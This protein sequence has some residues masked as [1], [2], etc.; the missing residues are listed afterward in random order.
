[1]PECWRTP[2]RTVKNACSAAECR[3]ES[4]AVQPL[5]LRYNRAL[6]RSCHAELSRVSRLSTAMGAARA[7]G[8]ACATP[9]SLNFS[10]R[11]RVAPS[12]LT[13]A[14]TSLPNRLMFTKKSTR[15]TYPR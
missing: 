8:R 6:P 13:N 10:P 1:M 2:D 4:R 15:S 12:I 11:C 9:I 5:R 7:A 14:M 3:L